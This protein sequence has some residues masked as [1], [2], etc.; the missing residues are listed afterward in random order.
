[1]RELL[2]MMLRDHESRPTAEDLLESPL[3]Q[4]FAYIVK[5]NVSLDDSGTLNALCQ[6]SPALVFPTLVSALQMG[7]KNK[8]IVSFFALMRSLLVAETPQR[9]L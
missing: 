9:R 2:L 3:L 4:S 6:R 5:Q 7:D 1:M 8:A